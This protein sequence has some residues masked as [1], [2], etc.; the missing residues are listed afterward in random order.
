MTYHDPRKE[1]PEDAQKR[2]AA[3]CQQHGHSWCSTTPHGESKRCSWCGVYK[4][5]SEV[6]L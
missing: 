6:A 2:R 4:P 3:L 1:K 5:R